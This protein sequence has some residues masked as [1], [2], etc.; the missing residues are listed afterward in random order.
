M[1]FKTWSFYFL[2]S[3]LVPAP[4]LVPLI[5]SSWLLVWLAFPSI[6]SYPGL[7]HCCALRILLM[8]FCGQHAGQG[9]FP[10]GLLAL[11]SC[12]RALVRFALSLQKHLFL[13]T[14]WEIS[15]SQLF[16]KAPRISCWTDIWWTVFIYL[17]DLF[18][19]KCLLNQQSES[20]GYLLLRC[21]NEKQRLSCSLLVG[22]QLSS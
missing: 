12:P 7:L 15:S 14:W 18:L 3:C 16:S 19:E 6:S 20:R 8:K 21:C 1:L 13:P 11:M 22:D 10:S 2:I 17:S 4:L 5:S 9:C